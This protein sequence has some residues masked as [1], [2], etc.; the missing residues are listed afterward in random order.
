MKQRV[1]WFT[2]SDL[3]VGYYLPRIDEILHDFMPTNEFRDV[4]DV[5]ELYE[6]TKFVAN[7]AYPKSWGQD[8]LSIVG[9]FKPI[10]AKYFKRIT[11]PDFPDIYHSVDFSLRDTFWEVIDVFNVKDLIDENS[12]HKA[13]NETWELRELMYRERLVEHHGPL[14]RKLLISNPHSAE[15]L[16]D[17]YVAEHS[18]GGH[19]Q[20]FFPK[21]LTSDDV[22]Q[23]LDR[24]IASDDP[25]LNYVRL[26]ENTKMIH[27]F[28]VS[29]PIRVKAKRKAKLL[30]DK[31]FTSD[32]TTR[33]HYAHSVIIRPNAASKTVEYDEEGTQC[34]VYDLDELVH[35]CPV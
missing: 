29:A 25:N 30:N 14:L 9:H 4:N 26:L 3:S 35:Y 22:S 15:W 28:K 13:F 11:K 10:A 7:K 31:I 34:V 23:I 2:L 19:K 5:L 33:M 24:Y 27:T 20:M 1:H 18:V 16:L 21:E 32:S 8:E 12:L 17:E 6:V